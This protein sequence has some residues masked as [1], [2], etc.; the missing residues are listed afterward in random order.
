MTIDMGGQTRFGPDT[1]AIETE[2]YGVDSARSINFE[3]SIR[4]YWPGLPDNSLLPG[5][6][7]IRPKLKTASS[8]EA[9]FIIDGPEKLGFEGI[10]ALYGIESPGLTS[11]LSLG[12]A[13]YNTMFGS[14]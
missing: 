6:A 8:R 5:Y 12:E 3:R 4:K 2:N 13:A 14:A 1:Q 7:G 9:D 10:V 11:S